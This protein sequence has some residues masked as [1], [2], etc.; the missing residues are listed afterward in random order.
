MLKRTG[1]ILVV[2]A[3]FILAVG[4]VQAQ[5]PKDTMVHGAN[6]DIFISMDPGICFE[7]LPG[8]ISQNLY[9]RLVDV[10]MQDGN[11]VVVPDLAEKWE[12]A[13]DG[14]T[15]TF[16]LRDGLKFSNGD[17]L[18]AEDVVWSLQRVV[19]LQKSPA[20]L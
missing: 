16:H 19:K 14:K 20:W 13:E 15:W 17:P 2:L 11:F 10:Q 9:A 4:T 6:T 18:T 7:V 5:I 8:A 1:V 12:T 3:A